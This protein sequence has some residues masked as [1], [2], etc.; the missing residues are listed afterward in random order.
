[1]DFSFLK[2]KYLEFELKLSFIAF[3]LIIFLI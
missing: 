3:E 1:L 2:F